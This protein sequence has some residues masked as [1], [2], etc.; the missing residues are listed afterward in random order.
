MLDDRDIRI[1]PARP[2]DCD[3]LARLRQALWPESPAR[4]HARELG[5]ILDGTA[6]LT[7][8]VVHFV[9]EAGDGRLVGFLEAGLRSHADGCDPARAVGFIE[10]WYVAEGHRRLGIGRQLLTAAEHWAR[11][12]G[13]VEMASD[14]WI[15]NEAGQRAHEVL[16][17][18]IVDRCVHYRKAL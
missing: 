2:S 7:M 18:T 9:A 15:D 12:Q 11:S 16:G 10:G 5:P 8:P 6:S 17:F 13:C 3:L 14:T 1:R 4:E